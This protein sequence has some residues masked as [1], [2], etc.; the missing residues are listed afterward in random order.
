MQKLVGAKE[1]R[2]ALPGEFTFEQ[3]TEVMGKSNFD[4]LKKRTTSLGVLEQI[5]RGYC[6]KDFGLNP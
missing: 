1:S 3:A 5:A 4:R 6:R 2:V